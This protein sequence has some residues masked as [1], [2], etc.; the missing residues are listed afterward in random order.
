MA[1][2]FVAGRD[3]G[4]EGQPLGVYEVILVPAAP[5]QRAT[6]LPPFSRRPTT[7]RRSPATSRAC[8]SAHQTVL[9]QTTS[10]SANSPRCAHSSNLRLHVSPLG[11][12]SSLYGTSE[13]RG[14]REQHV[15]D[16]LQTLPRR[17]PIPAR[18]PKTTRRI[19]KQR[20]QLR[21]Q[22]VRNPPLQQPSHDPPDADEKHHEKIIKHKTTP[23]WGQK[24]P[25]GPCR[26]GSVRETPRAA[27][28]GGQSPGMSRKPCPLGG[29]QRTAPGHVPG[30]HVWG[31]SPALRPRR[32]QEG[33]NAR[34]GPEGRL[35]PRGGRSTGRERSPW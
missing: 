11:N 29:S 28:R 13:P 20:L 6:L 21:P 23:V 25:T 26:W 16:P 4:L 33:K 8:P 5:E 12:P 35:S 3:P 30:R 32:A 24:Q 22:L 31:A 15:Q 18:R 34:P 9:Q 1:F 10:A 19:D 2:V 27:V 7:H 14:I 17:I